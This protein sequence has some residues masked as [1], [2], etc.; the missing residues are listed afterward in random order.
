MRPD[1]ILAIANRDLHIE[2]GGRRGW[3]L[4]LVA[5]IILG[6]MA[7]APP[8]PEK[9][10][11]LGDLMVGG[12]VPQEVRD[13]PRIRFDEE[14]ALLRFEAPSPENG[15]VWILHGDS[16]P[17]E[18]REVMEAQTEGPT[19]EVVNPREPQFP[20]RSLFLALI[21]ASVLTGSIS[22]SIPGE[23]T[24]RT[25]EALLTA[26]ITR[27]EL[28]L[29][30]WL[31]WGGF[32][33]TVALAAA[34]VTLLLGRQA[35]GW[36]L[37][38]L[39]LVSFGTVALGFFLVRRANDVVGG[40]T[41][42]IRVLPAVLTVSGLLSWY[43]GTLDPY[44]GALIPIG[45]A[46]VA[47]GDTWPGAG[48]PLVAALSTLALCA[49]AL[50]ITARD[51]I[52]GERA[53]DDRGHRASLFT[54]GLALLGWWGGVLSSLVWMLGGN[55]DVAAQL[56]PA[57]G[58]LAGAASL[59]LLVMIKLGRALRP[60]DVVGVVP[61]PPVT[62]L[63]AIGAGLALSLT[64][65]LSGLV[66][67]PELASLIEARARLEGALNPVW[68]GPLTLLA[69]IVGQE[70]L[71]RGWMRRNTV[72]VVQVVCFVLVFAPLDPVRGLFVALLLTGLTRH[73]AGSVLPAL[74]ARLLWA[75]TPLGLVA[76]SP[77]AALAIAIAALAAIFSLP[78]VAQPEPDPEGA[79]RRAAQAAS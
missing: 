29:G 67:S 23:R 79:A 61:P 46:L 22:Q 18:V 1:R 51:I 68:A 38:P 14:R 15:G 26:G 65:P 43:L 50:T 12:D 59:L 44:Y 5:T 42:A 54:G 6:P 20:N 31:A 41:V 45:G 73:A 71:F 17:I 62:W 60:L 56:N 74:L 66:P 78:V 7:A 4:P 39:P 16:V 25:L 63:T 35:P 72:D 64:A 55:S 24:A 9:P 76:P 37:L 27:G 32:G 47:A 40:A 21:A 49:G 34:V 70:L 48:P 58:P 53:A 30:K 57:S 33:G 77:L 69:V 11:Y 13:L 28:V 52:E 3:L 2:L 10:L 8:L 75:W 19:T 36:W